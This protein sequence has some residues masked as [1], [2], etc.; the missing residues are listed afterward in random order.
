MRIHVASHDIRLE[1]FAPWLQTFEDVL[2]QEL[3]EDTA[4]AWLA[5]AQRIG[6]AFQFQME[7]TRRP[8][9]TPPKLI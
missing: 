6:R 4:N 2:R 3:P 9:T 7:D 5:L 8:A 1:H